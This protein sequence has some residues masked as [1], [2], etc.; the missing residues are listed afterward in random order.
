MSSWVESFCFVS[1]ASCTGTDEVADDC[2]II[3]NDKIL[4]K[5]LEGFLYAFMSCCMGHLEHVWNAS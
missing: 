3:I 1:L 4:A 2:T 5:A